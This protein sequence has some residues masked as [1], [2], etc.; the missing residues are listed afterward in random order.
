MSDVLPQ[1]AHALP[2]G[3]RGEFI[4]YEPFRSDEDRR[5]RNYQA[6]DLTPNS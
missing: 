2:L 6:A 4:G 3:G 1:H 5:S